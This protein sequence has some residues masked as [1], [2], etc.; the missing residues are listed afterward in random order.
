MSNGRRG[1]TLV[2]IL[3]V[4]IILG[5]LAAIVVPRLSRAS[6]DARVNTFAK[7]LK[8]YGMQ[9][10]LYHDRFGEWPPDRQP[11]EFPQELADQLQAERWQNP[12]P[13]GGSWDWDHDVFGITAGISI[14]EPTEN[15][16][17]MAQ[18]DKLID[19]G[20]LDTGHFRRRDQGYIFVL[21]E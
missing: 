1:F 20:D 4:V 11:G 7:N 12:S 19:D 14:F 8:T 16:S 21:R 17:T 2:E 5:I 10:E 9:L 13:L 3:V 18:I 15:E 6:V